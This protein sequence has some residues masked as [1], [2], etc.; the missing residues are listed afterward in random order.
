MSLTSLI[1]VI[2]GPA[3]W[4]VEATGQTYAEVRENALREAEAVGETLTNESDVVPISS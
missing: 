2:S 1:A 3:N 4:K